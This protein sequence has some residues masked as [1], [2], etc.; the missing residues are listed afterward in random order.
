[1]S[2]SMDISKD[3][4]EMFFKPYQISALGALW[5]SEEG[6]SSREVWEAV[7][8]NEISRASIIYFLEDMV[9]NGILSKKDI[10][11]KGGHRGIYRFKYDESGTKKYLA[12]LFSE[13]LEQ[14]VS[15]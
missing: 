4:L 3:D 14:L 10:T 7:G 2:L 6:M 13:K 15:D 8:V 12:K 11:G 5:E 9:E 1:M